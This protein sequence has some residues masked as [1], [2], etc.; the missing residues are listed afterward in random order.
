MSEERK[1]KDEL[2][3]QICDKKSWYIKNQKESR[4]LSK[5][6]FRTPLIKIPFIGE[7]A[8]FK[9]IVIVNKFLLTEN[10]Y[11]PDI[12]LRLRGFT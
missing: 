4:L 3:Y 12:H 7:N 8:K 2:F 1:L 5:L 6:E 10:K 11:M 9:I